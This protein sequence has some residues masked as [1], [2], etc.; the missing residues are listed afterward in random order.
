METIK[1]CNYEIEFLKDLLRECQKRADIDTRMM[2]ADIDR[3][4][5]DQIPDVVYDVSLLTGELIKI[6]I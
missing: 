3:H 5:T 4:I 2:A 6:K 1:L